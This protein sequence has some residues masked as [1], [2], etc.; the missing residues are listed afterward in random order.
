MSPVNQAG[1]V[2]EISPRYSLLCKLKFVFIRE[3]GFARLQSRSPFLRPRSRDT[4]IIL[5]ENVFI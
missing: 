3:A 2:S 4:K 1:S 5:D